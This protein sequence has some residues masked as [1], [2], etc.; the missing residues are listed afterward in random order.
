MSTDQIPWRWLQ[1]RQ[2]YAVRIICVWIA[3][4]SPIAVFS[5]LLR[6]RCHSNAE[7]QAQ[8]RTSATSSFKALP[9]RTQNCGPKALYVIL[10]ASQ[11]PP[12]FSELV[13]DFRAAGA[14]PECSV[15]QLAQQA[16]SYGFEPANVRISFPAL[17]DWLAEP[18]HFAILHCGGNHFVA[19]LRAVDGKV[20]VCDA[21][22]GV[23]LANETALC[24]GRYRWEGIAILFETNTAKDA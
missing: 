19:A 24:G 23:E 7:S 17:L 14:T 2:K 3:I 12:S 10:A 18:N 8:T 11:H 6:T 5:L 13:N 21:A 20:A 16:R 4:S 1:K 9:G 15:L 22:I